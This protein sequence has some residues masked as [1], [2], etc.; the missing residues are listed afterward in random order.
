MNS[1]FQNLARR[2]GDARPGLQLVS[3]EE[4][5][6]PVTTL[7]VDV[8]AQERQALPITEEFI[9]RYVAHGVGAVEE[10]GEYLGLERTHVIEAAAAQVSAGSLRQNQSGVLQ[11]TRLGEQTAT[12]LLS[13][14]PLDKS[15]PIAFDRVTWTIAGYAESSLLEKRAAQ[16]A[17]MRIL[18]AERNAR[19]TAEDV[20]V[21]DLNALLKS[22]TVQVLRV[23]RAHTKK[24][25]YLPVL[26]LVYADTST[27]EIELAVC[28]EDELATDHGVALVRSAAVERLGMKFEGTVE[29]PQLAPELEAQRT[30]PP[31]SAAEGPQPEHGLVRSVSVFEHP[32]LLSEA[33]TRTKKRLLLISPWVRRAVIT[34][35][36]LSSIEQRLREG[37][38]VT[39]AHGYGEDDR[40]SD[41]DA[42]RRLN[43]LA[44]RYPKFDFVRLR[45]THAKILIFDDAWI[46][47]SFNWMSF[48]GDPDRTYRMEEGTIVEVPELVQAEYERYLQLIAEQRQL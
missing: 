26:L 12:D 28:I 41:E 18:P 6:L 34:T 24:H 37:V 1:T 33:V 31:A 30:E 46:S 5:A 16:D 21:A 9:L 13:V 19:I 38:T 15:L 2:F 11:L 20:P 47:T 7:R 40:G 45:N 22:R 14:R 10:I 17:G 32:D 8:L 48:K 44:K 43:N 23:R 3:V 25:R 36:F 35:E 39:I 27:G 42:L 4:A 29:R